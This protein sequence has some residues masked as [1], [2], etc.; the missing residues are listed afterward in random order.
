[1]IKISNDKITNVQAPIDFQFQ[2][3]QLSAVTFVENELYDV[4]QTEIGDVFVAYASSGTLIGEFTVSNIAISATSTNL[5]TNVVTTLNTGIDVVLNSND[6]SLSENII[7]YSH[8][9]NVIGAFDNNFVLNGNGFNSTYGTKYRQLVNSRVF[10]TVTITFNQ[11]VPVAGTYTFHKKTN[12]IY[13]QETVSN[14]IFNT[15]KVVILS[16]VGETPIFS[17]N[18]AVHL[19]DEITTSNFVANKLSD[20]IFEKVVDYEVTANP[21][22]IKTVYNFRTNNMYKHARLKL[23]MNCNSGYIESLKLQVKRIQPF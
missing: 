19:N 17:L 10:S 3:G 12:T 4:S 13:L 15:G 18:A 21:S 2:L 20:L 7:I 22:L 16:E 8:G 9:E 23:E 1:M 6:D 5:F 11:A 14:T